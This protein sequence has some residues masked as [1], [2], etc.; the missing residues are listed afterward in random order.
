MVGV[1]FGVTQELG[2]EWMLRSSPTL[3]YSPTQVL[4]PKIVMFICMY[5]VYL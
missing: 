4:P 3:T 2:K 1:C 5:V